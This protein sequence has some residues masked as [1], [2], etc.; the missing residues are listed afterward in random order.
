MTTTTT[1]TYTLTD[2]TTATAVTR[3]FP[4]RLSL[5]A[6]QPASTTTVTVI[7]PH[8]MVTIDEYVNHV[9][10]HSGRVVHQSWVKRTQARQ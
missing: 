5:N 2:G 1:Q 10:C 8:G 6:V 4:I 7:D 9:D 3:E